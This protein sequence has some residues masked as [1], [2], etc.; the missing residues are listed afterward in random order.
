MLVLR[1]LQIIL[2]E[3]ILYKSGNVEGIKYLE[4]GFSEIT[5]KLARDIA[6]LFG[7]S[8]GISKTLFEDIY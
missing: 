2:F 5:K 3:K 7:N 6:E 1:Y 8:T 4:A